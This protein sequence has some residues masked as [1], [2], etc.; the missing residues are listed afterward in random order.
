MRIFYTFTFLILLA[1]FTSPG[2][3]FS[4]ETRTYED[5]G[6]IQSDIEITCDQSSHGY[7]F[8]LCQNPDF[9]SKQE[10]LCINCA[11]TTWGLLKSLFTEAY[12]LYALGQPMSYQEIVETFKNKEII[13]INAMSIYNFYGPLR[14]SPIQEALN[15]L[16]EGREATLAIELSEHNI[17][18]QVSFMICRDQNSF[19][20][21][22][23][24][25][26]NRLTLNK[27][28]T[29]REKRF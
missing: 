27:L 10:P 28:T 6:V 14:A 1:G 23:E 24:L 22:F 19:A 3:A 7:C 21:Y 4:L 29:L 25:R 15:I 13:L 18:K 12:D 20:H 8:E 16:C 11:G 5:K 26:S 17:P 9:C 2:W